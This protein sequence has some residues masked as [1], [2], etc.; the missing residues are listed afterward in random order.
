VDAEVCAIGRDCPDGV[1]LAPEAVRLSF[2]E[3]RKMDLSK[4]SDWEL[5]ERHTKLEVEL[6][7]ELL[8]RE[9]LRTSNNPT[10]DI[11]EHLFCIACKW[12]RANNSRA[13]FDAIG[14]KGVRYQIKSRR[15]VRDSS[16]SRQLS[17]I[18]GLK[19]P[20][21]FDFLA[22][23]LFNGDYSVKRAVLIPHAVVLKLATPD[24]HV[25]GHR[26]LLRDDVWNDKWKAEGV[27]DV[28]AKLQSVW[29]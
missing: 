13:G 10:G 19:G 14:K 20:K 5:L 15:I 6:K 27:R 21:H 3:N 25:N 29:H 2:Q 11:A 26:F 4:L 7:G 12:K 28:T 16:N 23:V 1:D 22:G 9:I 8:R 24:E 17:A 18:R